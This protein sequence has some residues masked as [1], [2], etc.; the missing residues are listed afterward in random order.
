ML[1][2]REDIINAN[3]LP[4]R[5]VEV[6]EWGGTVRVS[7]MSGTARE[8][9]EIMVFGKDAK[10]RNTSNMRGKLVACT[11]IDEN[12]NLLFAVEDIEKLGKKSSTALDRVFAV[13]QEL[14]GFGANAVDNAVGNSNAAPVDSSISA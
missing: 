10:S 2:S 6:P 7:T 8:E 12:G 14:N 3:D 13:A 9:W 4:S 1:L 11:L 5:D